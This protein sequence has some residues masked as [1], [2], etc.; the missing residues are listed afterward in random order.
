[1]D[2]L[3]NHIWCSDS[4][5]GC[6]YDCRHLVNISSKSDRDDWSKIIDEEAERFFDYEERD[7]FKRLIENLHKEYYPEYD[8]MFYRTVKNLRPHVLEWL[9][10]NVADR[11]DP[12][13][14]KGW[15]IGSMEYRYTDISSLTVFFHRKTDAMAFIK[16]FSKYGKATH[17]CQYFTDVRKKLNLE[18]MK[19]ER[20]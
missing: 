1:M 6:N 13:C 8:E 15:C 18:T 2:Y 12:D 5:W 20:V 17:Y 3:Q 10:E 4:N 7:R 16:R 9:E 19:Y 14:K 11:K